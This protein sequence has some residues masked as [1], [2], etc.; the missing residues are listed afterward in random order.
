MSGGCNQHFEVC[1]RLGRDGHFL[2]CAR[3][4]LMWLPTKHTGLCAVTPHAARTPRASLLF[5]T[6]TWF[7]KTKKATTHLLLLL[8]WLPSTSCTSLLLLRHASIQILP[9]K[10]WQRPQLKPHR[11]QNN[12]VHH[13]QQENVTDAVDQQQRKYHAGDG[14]G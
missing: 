13:V 3:G 9:H 8:L 1:L 10:P 12:M 6:T 14:Q 5:R 4:W 7:C 2:P 11:P